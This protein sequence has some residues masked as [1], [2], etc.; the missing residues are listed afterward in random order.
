[1]DYD[2]E[3][4]T[5]YIYAEKSHVKTEKAQ[6]VEKCPS[7]AKLSIGNCCSFPKVK[8]EETVAIQ[9]PFPCSDSVPSLEEVLMS[10]KSTLPNLPASSSSNVGNVTGLKSYLLCNKIRVY[11]E[12]PDYKFPAGVSVL[13]IAEDKWVAV[14]LEASN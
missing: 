14:S 8:T 12:F 4:I 1:M 11:T 6:L 7:H 2:K 9:T 5:H 3:L 13:P 10:P